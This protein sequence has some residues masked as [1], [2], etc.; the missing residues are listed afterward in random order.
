MCKKIREE[1][2]TRMTFSYEAKH[3]KNT[4]RPNKWTDQKILVQGKHHTNFEENKSKT[5]IGVLD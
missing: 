4:K 5:N 2:K 3:T 1:K